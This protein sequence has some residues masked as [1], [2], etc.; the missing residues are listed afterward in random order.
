[1]DETIQRFDRQIEDYCRPF[2]AS[3]QLLDTIPGVVRDIA[4][5]IISDI[6]TDMSRFPTANH[7]AAR[8]G[9]AP[10]NNVSTGKQYSGR[11]RQVNKTLKVALTQ[12]AHAAS[13]T[14]NT[15]LSAQYHRL[16][17]QRGKKRAIMA[18]AHS[19]LIIAYHMIL[20]QEPYHDF[21]DN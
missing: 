13:R 17:G 15:Y 16:A 1:M 18:V 19:I 21:G 7:L 14:K 6:G 3:T 4:E 9:V 11:T 12:M 2:E 5:I 20:R 10:G 8:A